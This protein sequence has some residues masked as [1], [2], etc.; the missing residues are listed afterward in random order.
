MHKTEDF[1]GQNA[2]YYEERRGRTEIIQ[3]YFLENNVSYKEEKLL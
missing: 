3:P 2:Q 1:C